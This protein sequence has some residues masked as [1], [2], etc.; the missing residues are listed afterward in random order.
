MSDESKND[1]ALTT[2][3]ATPING[4]AV[5]GE[6]LPKLRTAPTV[7][8]VAVS[9]G[10]REVLSSAREVLQLKACHEAAHAIVAV[11][12]SLGPEYPGG[13][14]AGLPSVFGG[15]VHAAHVTQIKS[16]DVT[17][18]GGGGHTHIARGELG[19]SFSTSQ[20]L[21]AAC[22]VALAGMAAERL[23]STP[24]EG[25]ETDLRSATRIAATVCA[26]GADRAAVGTDDEPGS[27][28]PSM[29][30]LGD[31]ST[32]MLRT[33]YVSRLRLV[34]DDAMREA[35]RICRFRQKEIE[36]LASILLEAGGRLSDQAVLDA[37]R[38]VNMPV[39]ESL[40]VDDRED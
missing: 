25:G 13:G 1:Q 29:D 12:T 36:G 26:A 3:P 9:A 32:E 21:A 10:E 18:R 5:L 35:L 15:R 6:G 37:L 19:R 27:L 20:D 23:Y 2:T 7:A 14:W 24:T 16:I 31:K 17:D 28:L 40:H 4:L 33:E 34:L 39:V 30:S 38:A 22:T 11:E 8:R